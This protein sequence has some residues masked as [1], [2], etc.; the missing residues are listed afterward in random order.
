MSAPGPAALLGIVGWSGSGK[1]T[2]ILSL[3]KIFHAA[4][5]RV[6]TIKHAHHSIELD[7]PDK[8]SYLHRAAGATEVMLATPERWFLMKDHR[9]GPEPE[10]RDLIARLSPVD[11]VLVEGFKTAAISQIEVHRPHL[12]RPLFTNDHGRLLA[13][14]SDDP[15]LICDGRPVLPL[16]HPARIAAFIAEQFRLATNL[17]SLSPF[18]SSAT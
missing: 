9:D 5:L 1:T 8:D 18:A 7:H 3:L 17:R 13:T 12:M 4:G 16:N 10:L 11:L 6:S 2:L 15:A 14:A